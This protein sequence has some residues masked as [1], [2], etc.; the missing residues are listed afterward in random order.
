[1][2]YYEFLDRVIEEGIEAARQ[3]YSRPE[4]KSKLDGSIAGF[5][6]CNRLTPGELGELLADARKSTQT[7]FVRAED[8]STVDYWHMRCL[9]AE[10]EWVCNVVSAMLLANGQPPILH[11]TA[12]GTIKAAEILNAVG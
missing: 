2:N 1:M 8:D 12:R 5:Q 7:A 10:V 3:D 9:E 11:P 6:K 4:Q